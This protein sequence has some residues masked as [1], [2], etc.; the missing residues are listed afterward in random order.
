MNAHM[1]RI[2]DLNHVI[3][4]MRN[5]VRTGRGHHTLCAQPILKD[6]MFLPPHKIPGRSAPISCSRCLRAFT[7][8]ENSL[9]K[10]FGFTTEGQFGVR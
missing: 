8:F 5:K 6:A 3:L 4:S 9:E 10:D 1:F 7:G 2:G